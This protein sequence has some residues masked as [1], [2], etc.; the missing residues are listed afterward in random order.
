ML[1][2]AVDDRRF[3]ETTSPAPPHYQRPSGICAA[4]SVVDIGGGADVGDSAGNAADAARHAAQSPPPSDR[5]PA[6][7]KWTDL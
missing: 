7:F 6:K 1:L 2:T 3:A 5:V 4:Y